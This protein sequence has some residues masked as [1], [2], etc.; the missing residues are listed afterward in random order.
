[1]KSKFTIL[2]MLAVFRV[3]QGGYTLANKCE[4]YV[5][6]EICNSIIT[7]VKEKIILIA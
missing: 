3:P 5:I 7:L 4:R 1:M 2:E 6:N